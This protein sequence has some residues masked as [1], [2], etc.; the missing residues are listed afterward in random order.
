MAKKIFI[1]E[2]NVA[3]QKL[4]QKILP[5]DEYELIFESKGINSV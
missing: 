4:F 3:I 5:S 2:N 1:A